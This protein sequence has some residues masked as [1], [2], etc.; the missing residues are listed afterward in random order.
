MWCFC[1]QKAKD[2]VIFSKNLK[3]VFIIQAY[4]SCLFTVERDTLVDFCVLGQRPPPHLAG[5]AQLGPLGTGSSLVKSGSGEPQNPQSQPPSQ[6]Q[7]QTPSSH[8]GQLH[9]SPPLRTQVA[10]PTALQPLLG[11]RGLLSPQLSP[12]IVQQQIAMAH[13]INQQLAVSRLLAHQHPQ[14]LNQQFLNHP[15]IPRPSKSGGPGEPGSNPSAAEVSSDIYQQVR[16][17][18][19]RASVSQAVFARVAF[20]RTQVTKKCTQILKSSNYKLSQVIHSKCNVQV[21][22]NSSESESRDSKL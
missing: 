3:E 13:L 14:A 12:Q 4:L 21:V 17:E 20:N 19:K 2:F 22:L 8:S 1:L 15:P 6:G 16:D 7:P 9:H 5:L 18:L 10:P 11:P